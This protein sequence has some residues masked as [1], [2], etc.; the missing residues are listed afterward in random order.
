MRRKR[1]KGKINEMYKDNKRNHQNAIS[2][3]DV[4]QTNK[5][6]FLIDASCSHAKLFRCGSTTSYSYV[7]YKCVS[8]YCNRRKMRWYAA[9]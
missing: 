6:E 2:I 1:R 5:K 9:L 4:F 7:R 3:H 8:K